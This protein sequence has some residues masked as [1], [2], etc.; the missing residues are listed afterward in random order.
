MR[1]Y[2]RGVGYPVVIRDREEVVT[3]VRKPGGGVGW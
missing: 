3:E 1:I 2:R